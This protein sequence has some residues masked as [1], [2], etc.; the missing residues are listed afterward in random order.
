MYLQ[1]GEP[2]LLYT[3]VSVGEVHINE[4]KN[5]LVMSSIFKWYAG[6]FGRCRADQLKAILPYLRKRQ[7]HALQQ[8]LAKGIDAV[9]IRYMDY[10]WSINA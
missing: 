10:D 1:G 7:Q 5:E 9:T 2:K 4:D 8:L 3:C 6:D